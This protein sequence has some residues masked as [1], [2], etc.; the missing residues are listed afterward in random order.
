[1]MKASEKIVC[2][3]T[4]MVVSV[5]VVK[6]FKSLSSETFV[7]HLHG[8]FMACMFIFCWCQFLFWKVTPFPPRS[9]RYDDIKQML[10]QQHLYVTSNNVQSFCSGARL[11]ELGMLSWRGGVSRESWDVLQLPLCYHP[12][13]GSGLSPGAMQVLGVW[14]G[15]ALLWDIS[16]LEALWWSE[17]RNAAMLVFPPGLSPAL[18][19]PWP[20]HWDVVQV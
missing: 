13:S 3:L 12:E 19:F 18:L 10:L 1:M 14:P 7:T 9:P 2:L 20:L 8:I 16:R 6:Y 5:I 4:Y 15:A 17:S 11:W